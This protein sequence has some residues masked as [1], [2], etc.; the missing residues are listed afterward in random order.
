M[1]IV[2]DKFLAV[3]IIPTLFYGYSQVIRT[4][5]TRCTHTFTQ[6]YPLLHE[7]VSRE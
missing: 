5:S 1:W 4:F 3:K 7:R 6:R 2:G